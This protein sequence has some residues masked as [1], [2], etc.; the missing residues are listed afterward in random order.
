MNFN[1][2]ISK[3]IPPWRKENVGEKVKIPNPDEAA[4][5]IQATWRGK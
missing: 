1:F 2:N 5:K 3:L 4:T